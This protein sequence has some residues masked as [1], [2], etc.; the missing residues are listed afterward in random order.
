[1][2]TIYNLHGRGASDDDGVAGWR[3]FCLEFGIQHCEHLIQT[4]IFES[5]T[6]HRG[7][8]SFLV[9]FFS[10]LIVDPIDWA[11]AS[12]TTSLDDSLVPL[13]L[14]VAFLFI[15]ANELT[16]YRHTLVVSYT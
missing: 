4:L 1:M 14:I 16:D 13:S 3:K 9:P 7:A 5:R 12:T 6:F 11:T 10:R 2:V 15:I 8:R